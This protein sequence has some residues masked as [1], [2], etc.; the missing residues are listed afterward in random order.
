MN[1]NLALNY[2]NYFKEVTWYSIICLYLWSSFENLYAGVNYVN[3]GKF[4][5]YDE[6]GQF[7]S[8]FTGSEIAMSLGYAY[9]I[10]LYDNS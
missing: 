8:E 7:T 5:G 3:Y 4:E 1:N 6:N 9:N 2:G 10:P